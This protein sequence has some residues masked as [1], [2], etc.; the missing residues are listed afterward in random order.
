M[1]AIAKTYTFV[2]GTPIESDQA[3][4]NFDDLVNYTNEEV[5]VRDASQA[6]TAIPSGPG[7]DPTSPNQFVRKQ[8]VDNADN[9]RVKID[10]STPFTGIPSGPAANPTTPNQFARKQYVDEAVA[11]Q[12][13]LPGIA[14]AQIRVGN[15]VSTTDAV[16]E[17][18]VN[19]DSPFPNTCI[20]VCITIGDVGVGSMVAGVRNEK[21]SRVGFQAAIWNANVATDLSGG[22]GVTR[23]ASSL[24]RIYYIAFG[25]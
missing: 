23:Q 4:Q 9:L 16:G 19:F 15:V 2:P 13:D 21:L 22:L 10:G 1:T 12:V 20:G 17:I 11:A 14:N 24:V 8:Y 18:G 3:N 7:I 6:F 5:I 25:N